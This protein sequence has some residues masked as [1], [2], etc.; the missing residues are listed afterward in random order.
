M[1]R[2]RIA[3]STVLASVAAI[4]TI[5]VIASA[6]SAQS[7]TGTTLNLVSKSV[8][9]IGF[10]FNHAPRPGDRIGFGSKYTG[11][12]TGY[13]RGICT[14]VTKKQA[15]CTVQVKLSTGS[16]SAQGFVTGAKQKDNP[17]IVTG[18]TG[19]YNGAR[20]TAFVTDVSNSTS[21]IRVELL[22]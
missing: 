15:L 11:A 20:G 7:P 8:N 12:Q 3:I 21:N 5:A 1:G 4:A 10:G 13:D 9:S 16:L 22:P 18:G 2:R 6:G 17:F 19:A 14:F